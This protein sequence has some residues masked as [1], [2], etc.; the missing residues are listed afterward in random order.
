MR[1][2][3]LNLKSDLSII[4]LILMLFIS[5]AFV[6]LN[7]NEQMENLI[8]FSGAC[9]IM[10]LTYFTNITVGLVLNVIGIFTA[11]SIILYMSITKGLSIPSYGY[12]WTFAYPIFTIL[13]SIFTKSQLELQK[14]VDELSTTIS[15][16]I[17][18]DEITKL[19]NE[20][21]LLND[22][23]IYMHLA[24]RYN[25]GLT[26]M[27]IG[28]RHRKEME[29]MLGKK[30]LD[31]LAIHLSESLSNLMRKE[32]LIYM[33]NKDEFTWCILLISNNTA[34]MKLIVDRIKEKINTSKLE[35]IP[36]LSEIK[37]DMRIGIAPY[38]EK[39]KT[40]FDFIEKAKAEMEYDIE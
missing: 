25:H 21:A 13:I 29:R 30:N 22:T 32:D 8:L 5:V 11:F 28:L 16:L 12:F 39:I 27:M 35:G 40:P 26:L 36:G 38:D 2:N 4:G 37:I 1:K 3:K 6:Y 7:S 24:K 34:S 10:L 15:N 20:K 14:K 17:T 23:E 18:T 19:K 33:M 31:T 9:T